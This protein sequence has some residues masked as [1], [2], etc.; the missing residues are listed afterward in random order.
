MDLSFVGNYISWQ[1]LTMFVGVDMYREMK[2]VMSLKCII[3]E[4]KWTRKKELSIKNVV[5]NS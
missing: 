3:F 1:K 5:R 4:V 2:S